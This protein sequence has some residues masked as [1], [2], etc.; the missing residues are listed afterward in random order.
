MTMC[1]ATTVLLLCLHAVVWNPYAVAAGM[2]D[3]G[4]DQQPL[5]LCVEAGTVSKRV[6]LNAREEW[7]GLQVL[8][9]VS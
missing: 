4:G 1:V 8:S 9:V 7:T 3:L 6:V 2:P 5:F